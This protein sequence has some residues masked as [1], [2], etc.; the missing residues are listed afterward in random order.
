M[1]YAMTDTW[2][3]YFQIENISLLKQTT[4]FNNK[5]VIA[6]TNKD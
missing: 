6:Q 1:A 4:A 3:H 5:L 2:T